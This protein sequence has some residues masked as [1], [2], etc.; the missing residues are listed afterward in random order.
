[1]TI[2]IDKKH[3]Y[4]LIAIV[5]AGICVLLLC[6]SCEKADYETIAKNMKLN[7]WITTYYATQIL[8]DYQQNWQSAVYDHRAINT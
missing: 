5:L 8:S 1:M 6:K 2:V 3:I 4:G 7:A